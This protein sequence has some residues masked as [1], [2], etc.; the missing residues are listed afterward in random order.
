M[1]IKYDPETDTLSVRLSA[2]EVQGTDEIYPGV[3][4]DY[5]SDGNIVQIEVL[6][7]VHQEANY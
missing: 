4:L 1:E 5:D 6:N 3:V 7:A 2:K